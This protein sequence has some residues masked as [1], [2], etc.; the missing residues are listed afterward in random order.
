MMRI[1]QTLTEQDVVPL[2]RALF[3]TMESSMAHKT[4]THTKEEINSIIQRESRQSITGIAV[5]GN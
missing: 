1:I 5:N 4:T 2:H 3:Y